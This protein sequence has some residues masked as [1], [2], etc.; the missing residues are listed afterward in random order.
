M[1]G[2]I[3]NLEQT[4]IKLPFQSMMSAEK[5]MK[6]YLVF[7]FIFIIMSTDIRVCCV[8]TA[9]TFASSCKHTTM[10]TKLTSQSI[11]SL[12]IRT[13]GRRNDELSIIR[14]THREQVESI[15]NFYFLCVH[16]VS[17]DEYKCTYATYLHD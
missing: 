10:P 17:T 14:E 2:K 13:M 4:T 15:I 11:C 12:C 5:R 16:N 8:G 6:I 7:D 1:S 9:N 3:R